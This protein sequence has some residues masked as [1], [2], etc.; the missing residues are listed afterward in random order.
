MIKTLQKSDSMAKA[1]WKRY[2]DEHAGGKRDPASHSSDFIQS[3][4][5]AY[6]S[7]SLPSPS[8]NIITNFDNSSQQQQQGPS[9]AMCTK[10]LQRA[11]PSFK[12]AWAQYCAMFGRGINDPNRHDDAYHNRFFGFLADQASMSMPMMN[13]ISMGGKGNGGGMMRAPM[14]QG[15]G[16]PMKRMRGNDSS[17]WG[18]SNSG[19]ARKDQLVESLKHF[20]RQ[21][22]Q[23]K[24]MWGSYSDM[25]L[26]GIRDPAR[27]DVSTLQDFISK[28][29]VPIVSKAGGG[30]P[31]GGGMFGGVSGGMHTPRGGVQGSAEPMDPAKAALVEKIKSFQRLGFEQKETWGAFAGVV[32]DPAKQ[33]VYKLQEFIAMQGL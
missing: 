2:T 18:T 10:T 13:M 25:Y 14:N 24:E 31:G 4:L 20:Q 3:F 32:R 7:G 26:G 27:H 30:M 5:D 6:H 11:N 16:G 28:N 17:P 9:L 23:N 15:M 22:A 19:D 21:H 8:S 12:Q 29:Q 1:Q 33:E